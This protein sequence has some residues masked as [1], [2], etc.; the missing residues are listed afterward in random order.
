KGVINVT[1]SFFI[2]AFVVILVALYTNDVHAG[3]IVTEGL[4]SFWSLDR[5]TISGEKVKDLI[6]NN[7]GTISGKP[8]EVAGKI[9]EALKFDG[10][11]DFI[12]CGKDASLD[13]PSAFTY[14][15]WMNPSSAGE[16]GPKNAGP[17]CKAINGGSWSWQLRYNAPGNN[18][19]GFQ[20]NAGGSVWITVEQK[21]SPNEWYHIIGTYDGKTAKCYLNGVKKSE[22]KMNNVNSGQDNFFI[23]QDGWVNVFDGI[24]DEVRVYKR[25]LDENEIQQNYKATSQLSVDSMNKLT[26]SWGWIKLEK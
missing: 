23:G 18:F 6:G 2:F 19:M 4:V 8:K 25:A 12:D 24:I 1:Q 3:K 7:H 16:G 20:F 9:K 15:V 26:G 10:A 13:L 5:D 14:E 11:S 17:I 21:L 22:T